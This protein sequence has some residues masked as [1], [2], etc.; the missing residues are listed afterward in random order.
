MKKSSQHCR[1][2]CPHSETQSSS[3]SA[4]KT[5][6]LLVL[7]AV[8]AISLANAAIFARAPKISNR[9]GG[10]FDR[11]PSRNGDI[12]YT[13]LGAG[14]P[15]L[16]LLHGFGAGNSS[17]EWNENIDAL[18]AQYSVYTLDFLGWGLSDKFEHSH[19]AADY[20]EAVAGFLR[21]VVNEPCVVLASSGAAPIAV[22]AA[23]LAGENV[24]GLILVCPSI[25]EESDASNL[26]RKLLRKVLGIPVVGTSLYNYIASRAQIEQF[27]RR[28]LFFDKTHVDD[29]W[30]ARYHATA[31]QPDAQYGVYAF[32][33]GELDLD[34]RDTWS[35][36]VVPALLVW[37]RNAQINPLETAPEWLALNPNAELSVIDNAMLMPHA[38]HPDQFN[39]LL[40]RW[41]DKNI[42]P[43]PSIAGDAS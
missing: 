19:T 4:W 31:H 28:H 3:K 32:L 39:A 26:T 5:S 27:S 21:D 16:L 30:V 6:A 42:A 20:V 13:V 37:G 25:A 36:L 18:A 2:E 12:A 29:A 41:V 24:A 17:F 15:P 43:A 14:K 7:G 11:Y 34:A 40:K 23:A 38:E 33:S 9:L 8:G 1:V 10:A 22:E 35:R